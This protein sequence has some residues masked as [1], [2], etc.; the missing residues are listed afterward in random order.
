MRLP[1][2]ESSACEADAH[3]VGA[4]TTT[5]INVENRTVLVATYGFH[6]AALR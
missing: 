4:E 1:P 2:A 5:G 6:T 3:H